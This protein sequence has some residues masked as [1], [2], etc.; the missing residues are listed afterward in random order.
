MNSNEYNDLVVL[1]ADEE[2]ELIGLELLS[3]YCIYGISEVYRYRMEELM[4]RKVASFS[5][6]D[7][8]QGNDDVEKEDPFKYFGMK[9]E[10]PFKD[11]GM[12]R[13][14]TNKFGSVTILT[15]L[16]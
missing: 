15:D 16:W 1:T 5:I 9:D 2:K 6:V 7:T 11:V 14:D 3:V 8:E 10:D 13:E 12:E 4:T